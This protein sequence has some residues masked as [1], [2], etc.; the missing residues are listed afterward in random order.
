M[1]AVIKAR[2]KPVEIEA[3]QVRKELTAVEAHEIYR[4]VESNTLGSFDVNQLWIDPENFTWPA[5]GI[6]IDARDGRVVIATLE[7]GHW[8]NPEDWIIRGIKGEFY[9]CKPDIFAATY[10]IVEN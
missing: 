8:V 7:G 6:S 2:K 4:W 9:S 5:S 10:D 3:V 1:T